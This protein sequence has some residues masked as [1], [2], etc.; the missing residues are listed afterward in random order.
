MAVMIVGG[1]MAG[2]TLALA[3]SR[4]SQ[5]TIPVEL[6]E[7]YSPLDREHPG[8]DA[9]AIALSDGT[10]QQLAALGI[11]QALSGHATAITDIH[12]SERGHASAVDLHASDYHVQAL[13]HVVE[14][15]D[16]GQR[17][18]SLLQQ[19]PGVRLHC[20]AKVVAVKRTQENATLTLDNGT[21]LTGQLLVAA[22]GSH[23]ML[24]QSC[25]IHWQ[26][27]AYDQI[28]VIANVT[29]TKPHC[30][31]AFERFT[32]HGPLALLPMNNGRCSLVWCHDQHRQA[33]VDGWSETE[34]RQ[35]LQQ[36]F[37]WRLGQFT[38]I[39]ERHSYPLR[40]LT[41]NQHISHRLALVGNAAQT[42]HPIAGQGF[43]LGIRDVMSLAETIVDAAQN[44]QDIGQYSVLS[45]YQQRREP[46][47]HT[48]VAIT[49]GLVRLFANRY[50]ALAVGRNLGLIAMNNL[51]LMRDAF[52]RRTLG[53]VKR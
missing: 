8:F 5:G 31:R 22:D 10:R 7:A 47:Q 24:S 30:G 15:H 13:G 36:A 29:T 28:A 38:H 12:V 52:A 2:A 37:G 34:F 25:G 42:L 41:A 32:P 4:L 44:L 3:I 9:R 45:R 1:G 51:P 14:L 49:D 40:L 35:Q 46:D 33:E 21:E 23:S 16:V 6:V 19:A 18:F 43:N 26:Q 27:H 50:T 11:W 48:T 20:P 17:L 39:G 53:W